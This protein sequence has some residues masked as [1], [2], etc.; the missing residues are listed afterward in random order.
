M[1]AAL[2]RMGKFEL[3][4]LY[5]RGMTKLWQKIE[6][7]RYIEGLRIA[8]F[9]TRRRHS[10]LWQDWCVQAMIEGLGHKFIGTSNCSIAR[11]REIEAI[12]TNAH[13][14][15]MVYAALAQSDDTLA[16]APYQ[17]LSIGRTNMMVICLLFCRI[18]M[19]PKDFL[20]M[21][22]LGCQAGQVC[23]STVEIL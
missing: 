10:F 17:V 4:V 16:K 7:L 19:V 2:K 11:Y 14:L 21:H 5:A 6:R 3:Q 9:G 18:H 8:D 13:E 20:K 22:L 15:P 23:A 12:G 1:G